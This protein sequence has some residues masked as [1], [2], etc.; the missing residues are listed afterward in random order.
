[1]KMRITIGDQ[2]FNATL[3]SSQA[4]KDFASLLPMTLN[5]SDYGGL[6]KVSDLSKRLST[7]GS[8]AGCSADEGDITYYSP[9]G[10]LAIFYKSFGYAGGLVKLGHI[11]GDMKLFKTSS[12]KAEA[13]FELED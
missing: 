13:L 7:N 6:E 10:N 5:L 2:V 4:A 1:M 12:E 9:W 3:N 11:N 8:P